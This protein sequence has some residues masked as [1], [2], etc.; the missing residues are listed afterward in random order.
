MGV[1]PG[2]DDHAVDPGGEQRVQRVPAFNTWAFNPWG[3]NT[4]A[5]DALGAEP[6]D[7]RLGLLRHDVGDDQR[8]D[9]RDADQ[10]VGVERADPAEPDES[11]PHAVDLS[12]R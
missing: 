2:R 4:W 5:L 3:F 8:V 11:E 1:G 6:L 9:R 7:D 12:R 10:G